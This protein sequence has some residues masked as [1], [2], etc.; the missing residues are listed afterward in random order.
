MIEIIDK[1]K[2]LIMEG[3]VIFSKVV[4]IA[5]FA[6]VAMLYILVLLVIILIPSLSPMNIEQIS[7]VNVVAVV[8]MSVIVA[9][10]YI[11]DIEWHEVRM[12]AGI[13]R[14]DAFAFVAFTFIAT[15]AISWSLKIF[16]GLVVGLSGAIVIVTVA[17]IVAIFLILGLEWQD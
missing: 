17:I 4:T 5:I 16:F 1:T 6:I 7:L 14:I 13:E 11:M 2:K 12:M 9:I 8:V 3:A 15:L 10:L